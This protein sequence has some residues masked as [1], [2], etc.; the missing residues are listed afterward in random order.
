M[1]VPK[2][3]CCGTDC[4]PVQLQVQVTEVHYKKTLKDAFTEGN[5]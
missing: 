5:I 2:D 4:V 1:N 3:I